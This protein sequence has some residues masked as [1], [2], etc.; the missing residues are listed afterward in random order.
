M[1]GWISVDERLPNA[2]TDVLVWNS[3]GW[4]KSSV[5]T[6][7][8]FEGYGDIQIGKSKDLGWASWETEE[9]VRGKVTHWQPLP[10][11]PK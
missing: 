9:E 6:A 11:P 4:S 8:L 3:H 1:S 10:E 5:I 7:G 2:S